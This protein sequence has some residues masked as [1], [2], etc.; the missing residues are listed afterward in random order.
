MIHTPSW[1]QLSGIVLERVV[2]VDSYTF[3][4]TAVRHC[5]RKGG[6]S[7]LLPSW[8]QL[9]GI[10]LERVVTVDSYTFMEIAVRQC[11]RKGGGS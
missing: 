10:M 9:S 4:E 3:M 1:K 5:V 2:T 11:D 8:K 6:D 7:W